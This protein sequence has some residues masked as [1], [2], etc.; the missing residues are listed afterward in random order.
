MSRAPRI[1]IVEHDH[2]IR[3]GVCLHLELEG[4][5][6]EAVPDAAAALRRDDLGRFDLVLYNLTTGLF[7]A[8]RLI[9]AVRTAAGANYIP[10]LMMATD[11][12]ISAGSIS[13]STT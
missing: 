10:I 1:L 12:T 9:D 7:E 4:C 2:A 8:Q 5:V 3:H 13:C 6:C 11:A